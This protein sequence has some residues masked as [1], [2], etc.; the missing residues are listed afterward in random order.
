MKETESNSVAHMITN[1][2][3]EPDA[4]QLTLHLENL[5]SHYGEDVIMSFLKEFY[6]NKVTPQQRK[7]AANE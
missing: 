4:Y 2:S 3:I 1:L 5:K 7:K 6:F